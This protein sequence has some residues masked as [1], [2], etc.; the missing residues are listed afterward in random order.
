MVIILSLRSVRLRPF[1]KLK[2]IMSMTIAIAVSAPTLVSLEIFMKRFLGI[3]YLLRKDKI[4]HKK[5]YRQVANRL[6]AFCNLL[7]FFHGGQHILRNFV[8]TFFT[9]QIIFILLVSDE[10]G[11]YKNA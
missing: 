10:A 6:F 2:P 11:F 3:S 1:R 7:I 5:P 9:I 8:L 4:V